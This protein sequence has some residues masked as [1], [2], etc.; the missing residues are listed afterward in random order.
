MKYIKCE[1]RPFQ[2]FSRIHLIDLSKRSLGSF[3]RMAE[4]KRKEN[5]NEKKEENKKF[6]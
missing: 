2:F 5:R 1:N 4:Q 6:K 3:L